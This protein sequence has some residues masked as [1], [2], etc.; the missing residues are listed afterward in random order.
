MRS[1]DF[2]LSSVTAKEDRL[3]SVLL[4]LQNAVYPAEYTGTAG[5]RAVGRDSLG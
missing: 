3:K 4:R 1:T 2:R 5:L